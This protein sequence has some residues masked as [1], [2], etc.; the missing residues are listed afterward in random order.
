MCDCFKLQNFL[1]FHEIMH[2]WLV[3]F[4]LREI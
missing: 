2:I 1:I 3:I 4:S